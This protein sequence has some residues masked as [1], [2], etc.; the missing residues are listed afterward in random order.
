VSSLR[1]SVEAASLP[2]LTRLS[3]LPRLVPFLVVLGLMVA[4]V[5]IP[6]WGFVLT[7]LVVLLLLWLLYLGWPRLSTPERMM[8]LAVLAIVLAVLVTQLFPR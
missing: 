7:V 5:L 8:R 1:T 3:R 4:G 6:G 2:A